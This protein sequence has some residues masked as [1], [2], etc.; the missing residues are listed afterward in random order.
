MRKIRVEEFFFAVFLFS[1]SQLPSFPLSPLFFKIMA[2]LAMISTPAVAAR[3]YA[4]AVPSTSGSSSSIPAASRAAGNARA[5][6]S[7]VVARSQRRCLSAS[8]SSSSLL[9]RR[10]ILV[11]ARAAPAT[12]SSLPPLMPLNGKELEE[13]EKGKEKEIANFRV[14]IF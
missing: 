6:A 5:S 2:S 11:I 14:D 8:S 3:P 10:S 13:R 7:V 12:T 9:K 1:L 4:C